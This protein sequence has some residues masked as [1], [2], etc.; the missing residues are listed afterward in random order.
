MKQLAT[1]FPLVAAV[2]ALTGCASGAF[3]SDRPYEQL[4]LL[5][6]TDAGPATAGLPV[7][8]VDLAVA[9]P[10]V[11]PGLDTDR[12]AVLYPDR[13]LDYFA[14]SRWGGTTDAVL[15]SLLIESLRNAGALRGV[16][17]ETS[18]FGAEYLL[19]TEV[20]DFQAEYAAG[21]GPPSVHVQLI[22]TLGRYA[23]RRPLTSF[24]A[25][26]RV[27]AEANSLSA[28]VAAFEKASQEVSAR[29]IEHLRAT[30]QNQS[31]PPAQ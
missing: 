19:Q 23:D 28:V 20:A 2:A 17:G 16:Q 13:R 7:L 15:R 9:Q 21:G 27:A 12:I 31:A 26:A 29:V 22:A 11:R 4:Y 18:A 1:L 3:D 5:S 6:G 14:A 10:Q 30:L 24:V 8:P 25:E